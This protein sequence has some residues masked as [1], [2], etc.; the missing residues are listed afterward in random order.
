MKGNHQLA[1]FPWYHVLQFQG[2]ESGGGGGGGGTQ[3]QNQT[4]KS[5][6]YNRLCMCTVDMAL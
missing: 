2:R 3:V 6:C 1:T 5:V 4:V